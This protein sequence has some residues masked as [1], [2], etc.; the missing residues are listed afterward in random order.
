MN[1]NK[2]RKLFRQQPKKTK[3]AAICWPWP[4]PALHCVW[5]VTHQTQF[6][7]VQ[8]AAGF[9]VV[10]SDRLAAAY[11]GE[12]MLKSRDQDPFCCNSSWNKT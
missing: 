3:A 11:I 4:W 8:P 2:R 5:A 6:G 7:Q 12:A 9:Y 10:D 1:R